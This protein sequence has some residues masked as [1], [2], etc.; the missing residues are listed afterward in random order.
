VGLLIR[1]TF[2]ILLC[3]CLFGLKCGFAATHSPAT[4]GYADVSAAVTEASE[5]D[6]DASRYVHVGASAA[7][8]VGYVGNLRISTP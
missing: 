8:V 2:L 1:K 5:G 4:C 7:D 6:T 3:V